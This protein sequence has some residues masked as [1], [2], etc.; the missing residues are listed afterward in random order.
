MR[1]RFQELAVQ[2]ESVPGSALQ[3]GEIRGLGAMVG[4]ELVTDR[5]T[6]APATAEAAEVVRRAWQR[7]VVAV[8]CGIYGNTLRMLV[9][10]VI[11]DDQLNEALD[12]LGQICAEI[13]RGEKGW[14]GGPARGAASSRTADSRFVKPSRSSAAERQQGPRIL[15]APPRQA[16]PGADR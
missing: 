10:L 2:L 13:A 1:R 4:V 5:A 3:I 6:R 8:K 7:G 9:P 15:L 16:S 11:T 12:I 14:P